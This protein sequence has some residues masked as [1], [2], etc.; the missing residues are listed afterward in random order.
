MSEFEM[1]TLF[2][3]FYN[4]VL[5]YFELFI[6]TLSAVLIVGYLAGPKLTGTMVAIIIGLFT[7]ITMVC[8][9]HT[10]GAY[11]DGTSLAVEI[12]R[13]QKMPGSSLHWM[14]NGNPPDNFIYFS[15]ILAI[16][17]VLAYLGAVV[18]FFHSRKQTA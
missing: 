2:L 9:W 10:M 17:M 1:A 15:P 18:F 5:S 13:I 11:S 4:H 12:G 8:M 14:F 7:M 3:D 16:V 6:A